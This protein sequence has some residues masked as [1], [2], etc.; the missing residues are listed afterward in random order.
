MMTLGVFSNLNSSLILT[1]SLPVL[2]SRSVGVML[3]IPGME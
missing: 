3:Y 2:W 1:T